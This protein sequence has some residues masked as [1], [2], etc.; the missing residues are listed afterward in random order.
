MPQKKPKTPPK[1]PSS[2]TEARQKTP[3]SHNKENPR[4]AK[5]VKR[6]LRV[7]SST[8]SLA[9]KLLLSRLTGAETQTNAN[10]VKRV[11]G[12]LKGPLMKIAQ[13]LATIPDALP[14]EYVQ[15]LQELQ[16]NAPPMGKWFV[17]RRMQSELGANWQNQ[18]DSFDLQPAHAASLGQVHF[19][20]RNGTALAVKL[21]YPDMESAITADLAQMKLALAAYHRLDATIDARRMLNELAERLAEELDYQREATH[22]KLFASILA[23]ENKI[24]VPHPVVEL[25]TK[26]LL[27]MNRLTGAPLVKWL[28]TKPSQTARNQLAQLLLQAWYLPFYRHGVLHGD[29]HLGNYTVAGTAQ[30]PSLNLLDFGCVRVFPQQFVQGVLDLYIAT[31]D[32]NQD[33]ALHAYHAWGFE[34][35]TKRHDLLAALNLWAEFIYAPQLE[36]KVQPIVQGGVAAEGSTVAAQV[37]QAIK[38][39][40]GVAPPGEFVLMDRSAVGLASVFSRLGAELNWCQELGKLAEEFIPQNFTK[41]QNEVLTIP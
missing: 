17:A 11:L 3:Q 21:Q 28:E 33:L 5:Q 24:A 38:A 36:D 12:G 9:I 39:A 4:L 7:S 29:P 15:A 37:Y 10:E 34:D 20:E 16:S 18:F 25:S 31:R 41:R 35:L 26:R 1:A 22:Q 27:T 40:G 32:K 30:N 14:P 8:S 19:A 13:L 23:Q 2:K 6:H